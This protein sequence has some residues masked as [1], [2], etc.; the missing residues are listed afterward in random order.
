LRS[1]ASHL[2]QPGAS[3]SSN[4]NTPRLDLDSLY[5][6]GPH[7][8]PLLYD[9]S[10]SNY[11]KIDRRTICIKGNEI[12]FN[13]LPRKLYDPI[14]PN[15][16]FAPAL[17]ADPRNDENIV[18]A[19]LHVAFLSLHN[20]LV[21]KYRLNKAAD[22]REAQRLTSWHYQ[23]IILYD[24][25]P[26]IV[27]KSLLRNI[28]GPLHKDAPGHANAC[29]HSN[30]KYFTGH[31]TWLPVEFFA[32]AFRMGH[33]MVR[34]SYNFNEY[35]TPAGSREDSIFHNPPN[36]IP[37]NFVDW[38]LFF[39]RKKSKVRKANFSKKINCLIDEEMIT[40]LPGVVA[41]PNIVFKNL[42]FGIK[43]QLPSGQSVAAHLQQQVLTS[44]E[45]STA[46]P[47]EY[48]NLKDAFPLS[49]PKTSFKQFC[50]N[51]PLWFY[52]LMEASIKAKGNRLGSVGARIVAEVIIGLIEADPNSFL[53]VAPSWTP[54]L[55][56]NGHFTMMD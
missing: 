22:F 50:D 51:S 12:S 49:N 9:L 43:M 46:R 3:V 40:R 11:F 52:I 33:S 31:Q 44:K 4:I 48:K 2:Q 47:S 37:Q 29:S 42:E 14:S 36:R 13:D 16:N 17:I 1:S 38:R 35:G 30:R 24:Y 56:Q 6:G 19:Q 5:G 32:A 21:K 34:S 25:L 23:W 7:I 53:A 18:L 28:L 10:R 54:E 27:G 15:D 20:Y 39:F 55:S 26:R 8:S 45:F 41:P